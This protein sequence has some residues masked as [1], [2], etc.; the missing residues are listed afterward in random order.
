M[1]AEEPARDVMAP[2][3]PRWGEFAGRVTQALVGPAF[4][5]AE[6]REAIRDLGVWAC[7]NKHTR[8]P[9]RFTRAMLQEFGMDEDG[10]VA[11]YRESGATCDCR[12]AFDHQ[13][14]NRAEVRAGVW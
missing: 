12:L 8:D 13:W 11:L 7:T 4:R 14:I 3:H 2:W 6:S 5:T 10:S 1:S 9:L